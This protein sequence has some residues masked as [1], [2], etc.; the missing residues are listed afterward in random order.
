MKTLIQMAVASLCAL[1]PIATHAQVTCPP[2]FTADSIVQTQTLTN[3]TAQN[4]VVS[5]AQTLPGTNTFTGVSLRAWV[6]TSE[7]FQLVN[8]ELVDVPDYSVDVDRQTKFLGNGLKSAVIDS[9]RS[10][11]PYSLT[12]MGNPGSTVI[13][14]PDSL[15]RQTLLTAYTANVVA[16]TGVGNVSVT[17]T[18]KGLIGVNGSTNYSVLVTSNTSVTFT[19]T[20]YFCSASSLPA[21]FGD[22]TAE[23]VGENGILYWNTREESAG[24]NYR[25]EGSADGVHFDALGTIQGKGSTKSNYTYTDPLPGDHGLKY[26]RI[27]ILYPDGTVK[28]SVIRMLNW[29]SSRPGLGIYP[30]PAGRQ[31]TV[32]FG[33]K[34]K[35]PIDIQLFNVTGQLLERHSV[36]AKDQTQV[37]VMLNRTY[38]PGT[39]VLQAI[40]A[41]GAVSTPS[42]IMLGL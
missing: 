12:A 6:N 2:G 9:L 11:G 32:N 17:Y 18:N 37:P 20:Y 34:Q 1:A 4:T 24:L 27:A 3:V 25:V 41:T 31:F 5:F 39:Y 23:K 35:G 30:N 8:R 28:Y 33:T 16:F 36:D 15:F 42:R 10:Y 22:L 19:M 26:Y 13:V 38:P 7:S 21:F 14:G 29:G 40:S